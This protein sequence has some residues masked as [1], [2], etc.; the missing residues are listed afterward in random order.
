MAFTQFTP[1]SYTGCQLWLD[2]TAANVL[3]QSGTRGA[4]GTAVASNADPVGLWLDSS[5]QNNDITFTGT[6]TST[7]KP[8]WN[9]TAVAAQVNTTL[10]ALGAVAFLAP[11]ATHNNKGTS[12]SNFLTSAF[13]TSFTLFVVAQGDPAFTPAEMVG[14]T[15]TTWYMARSSTSGLQMQT[16]NTTPAGSGVLGYNAAGTLGIDV[17]RYNGVYKDIAHV[18]SD[19]ANKIIRRLH[20]PTTGNVGFTGQNI[21]IGGGNTLNFAYQGDICEVVLYDTVLTDAQVAAVAQYLNNK[22]AVGAAGGNAILC[23]GNSL[24]FGFNTTLIEGRYPGADFPDQLQG[25]LRANGML[26]DFQNVGVTGDTTT[27]LIVSSAAGAGTGVANGRLTRWFNM[28]RAANACFFWEITNDLSNTVDGVGNNPVAAFNNVVTYCQT[29]QAEGYI[30][31]VFTCLPRNVA[32][33]NFEQNRLDVNAAIRQLFL[34]GG[35]TVINSNTYTA[36]S[37]FASALVDVGA[38]PTIG[39]TGQYTN[40][41]YY[42]ADGIHLTPAGYAIVVNYATIA[43]ANVVPVYQKS[44]SRGKS[45]RRGR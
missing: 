43:I 7:G 28:G 19:P 2:P 34:A 11:D 36:A 32:G 23:A 16:T 3:Y 21:I 38:D 42:A 45:A 30:T 6:G 33:L 18:D 17:A 44:V 14:D 35:T 12:A 24:T 31:I 5:G 26:W 29:R 41:T 13:N 39:Q 1:L 25:F 4:P 22:W 37:G 8:T 10:S 40:A 9:S 27:Q 15:G 20:V